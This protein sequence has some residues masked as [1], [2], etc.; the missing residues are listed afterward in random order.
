MFWNLSVDHCQNARSLLCWF[1]AFVCS[2]TCYRYSGRSLV[3]QSPRSPFWPSC[4]LFRVFI[5]KPTV[6]TSLQVLS[7]W[8]PFYSVWVYCSLG[9]PRGKILLPVTEP[10]TFFRRLLPRCSFLPF[11][12]KLEIYFSRYRPS[13]IFFC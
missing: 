12:M 3:L 1:R 2:A 10:P 6:Q 5:C 13:L 9:I 7:A 4:D 11:F 8:L